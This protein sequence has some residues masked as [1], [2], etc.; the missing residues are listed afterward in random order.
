MD[1]KEAAEQMRRE[2][3]QR[4]RQDAERFVYTRSSDADEADFNSSGRANYNQLV[5]PYLPVLL[6]GADPRDCRVLEI[7]CGVGRMTRWFAESFGEVHGIDIA[8]EMISQAHLR[9]AGHP[10]IRLHTGSGFDLQALPDASFDLV[11]SYIVFQH[12]PSATVIRNYVREA[13][14]VLKPQGA[15]KFQVNGDQ[16][17]AYRAHVR[18]TW[19]GETFSRDEVHEMLDAAGLSMTAVEDPGTQY[20]VVTSHKGSAPD[21]R[22]Y[23]LP[24][25]PEDGG[26]RPVAPQSTV[27]LRSP[28]RGAARLYAGMY[29]WPADPHGEH[30]VT[31]TVEGAALDSRVARGPGDHFL[32]W[33]LPPSE[34]DLLEIRMDISPPCAVPHWPSLRIVGI[35]PVVDQSL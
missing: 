6:N 4:A 26:W 32:E 22:T 24:G 7:G 13:A 8:P 19:Q 11:F 14:R 23:Y 3:N 25:E 16:S 15:F 17:A 2:W 9:L 20:F 35:T 30:C 5:R 33:P 34:S 18:D 27:R 28:G 29:F 12:I 31:M 10:N 1:L 21:R